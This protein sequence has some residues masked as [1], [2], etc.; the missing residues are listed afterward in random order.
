MLT[1]EAAQI[2]CSKTKKQKKEEMIAAVSYLRRHVMQ[3]FMVSLQR[4]G[5]NLLLY[6]PI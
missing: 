2:K 3:F 5:K 4:V 1:Y 6:V